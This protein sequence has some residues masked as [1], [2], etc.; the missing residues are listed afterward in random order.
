MEIS[1]EPGKYI[2]AVSGGVDSVVL[3]D[4]LAKQKGL[5]LIVAHFD[6]GIR[7]DSFKDCDFVA[8]LSDEYDLPFYSARGNLGANAS[9]AVAR[10]A[11]YVFLETLAKDQNAKA[12]ITAHHRDDLLETII[13]N[14]I[15]GTGRK[16]LSPLKSRQ[17][18]LR[19]MLDFT[20]KQILDYAKNR[21][22]S[23]REDE[24]NSDQKYLRNHIRHE[25][26]PKISNKD[27]QTLLKIGQNLEVS[28][29][30]IDK[31]IE[32]MINIHPKNQV[33]LAWFVSL[34]SNVAAEVIGQILRQNQISFDKKTIQRLVIALKTS[35]KNRTI[36]INSGWYLEIGK[37]TIG[38]G[39]DKS[40]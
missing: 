40:V 29:N 7:E 12:I 28:N 10:D 18:V 9:E 36:Q 13:L 27:K 38:L 14:L 6:H 4:L 21:S 24:T 32:E 20:K 8:K 23:W 3:L 22:L 15:R 35:G 34:P 37:N 33:D 17:S 19:P 39:R 1:L 25:I 26:V 16:G 11:R 30:E 5:D 2:V 31:L